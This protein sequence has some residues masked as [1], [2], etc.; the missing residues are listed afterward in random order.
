[1]NDKISDTIREVYFDFL[2]D[3]GRLVKGNNTKIL[4]CSWGIWALH[5]DT[6]FNSDILYLKYGIFK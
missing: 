3:K 1:M 5:E 6:G 2:E 4:L